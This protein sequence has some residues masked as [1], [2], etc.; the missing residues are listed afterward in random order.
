MTPAT[1]VTIRSP[2]SRAS[3]STDQLPLDEHPIG[4]SSMSDWRTYDTVAEVYDRVHAPRFADAAR[5]L[6]AA[7]AVSEDDHVLDVGTGTGV[8]AAAVTGVGASVVGLDRS[9]AMLSVGHRE[10]P[11]LALVAGQVID[12]PFRDRAFDVVMGNFVLAHFVKVET[13]LF[14]VRRVLRPHGRIG[15]TAWS[16]GKDAFQDAWLG[17]V[18]SVVPRDMLAPAYGAAAPGHERFKRPAAIEETL[19]KAGFRSIRT[20]RKRYQWT[21]G[22]D[23]L[24]EGLG[25][26]TVGRFVRNMLG[27]PAWASLMERTRAVFEERFPDPL[28]D[29]RDVILAVGVLP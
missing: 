22:R 7:L 6:V 23:E 21:Y 10:R 1:P 9:T 17:L 13:A 24:V 11:A 12:L 2:A 28:N 25:T 19:R 16:D 26:W 20:E 3:L 18:E 5:D 8:G 4:S 29:F 27:E 14:D 15:F